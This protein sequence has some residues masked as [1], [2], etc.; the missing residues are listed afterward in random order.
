MEATREH[1]T[2]FSSAQSLAHRLPSLGL[3][4]ERGASGQ[5]GSEEG[6]DFGELVRLA[7]GPSGGHLDFNGWE[8]RVRNLA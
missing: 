7:L 8:M 6:A 4:K 1:S 3:P 2:A 5:L